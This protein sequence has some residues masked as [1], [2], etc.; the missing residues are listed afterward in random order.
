V[1]ACATVVAWLRTGELAQTSA[2][3]TDLLSA[4][5]ETFSAAF[6]AEG[7]YRC[8]LV[9]NQPSALG[10]IV[11]EPQRVMLSHW[12]NGGAPEFCFG[13]TI[14]KQGRD[15]LF[16]QGSAASQEMSVLDDSTLNHFK[17]FAAWRI[18]EHTPTTESPTRMRRL[19]RPTVEDYQAQGLSDEQIARKMLTTADGVRAAI[20]RWEAKD[21]GPKKQRVVTPN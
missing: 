1:Q 10:W 20:R 9:N 11:E 4:E 3:P 6:V 15:T 19:H 5:W 2:S 18:A 12:F 8:S 16:L 13:H 7:I 21:A 14:Q 17:R